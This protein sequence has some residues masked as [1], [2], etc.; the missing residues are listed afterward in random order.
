[1]SVLAT[2]DLAATAAAIAV[3]D[4]HVAALNARDEKALAATLHFPH[5][6]LSGGKMKVWETPDTYLAD[7]YARAGA[8][9]DH[10]AWDHRNVVAAASDKVHLDVQFTR[11][12]ADDTPIGTFRALWIVAKLEGRWAA[13]A[14]SSFAA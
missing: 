9:W 8:D 2:P 11:Y 3:L 4:A 14:R 5:F 7:F 10:T 12:R 13:Q 1:M 6:R